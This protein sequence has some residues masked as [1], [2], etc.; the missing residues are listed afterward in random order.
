MAYLRFVRP[1]VMALC[2][3]RELLT[4]VRPRAI[5]TANDQAA[6]AN[7]GSIAS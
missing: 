6:K 2:R 3:T 1:R 4:F 5:D 7:S